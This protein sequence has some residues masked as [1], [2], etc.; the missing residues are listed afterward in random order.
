[1]SNLIEVSKIL[2]RYTL[3]IEIIFGTIGNVIN[4]F[5]FTRPTLRSSSCSLHF[6][7]G[8]AA[9]L[10]VLY[11]TCIV[12]LIRN[13]YSLDIVSSSS[14]FCKIYTWFKSVVYFLP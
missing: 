2:L 9:S 5:I 12:D 8:S 4:V 11:P 3:P 1:M 6:L 10:L 7:C 13:N 14:A